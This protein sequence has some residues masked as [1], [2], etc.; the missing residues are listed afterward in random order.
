[1]AE[2]SPVNANVICDYIIV[3]QTEINIK[4]YQRREVK[5][6]DMV[7]KSVEQQTFLSNDKTR[8]T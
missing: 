1:M 8:V 2:I 3:E 7:S 4:V 5:S 6:I